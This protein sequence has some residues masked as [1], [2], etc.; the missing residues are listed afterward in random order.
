VR[1]LRFLFYFDST[2][3]IKTGLCAGPNAGAIIEPERFRSPFDS[4]LVYETA[5]G[6]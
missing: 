5:L 6:G 2:R 1:S 3:A 4:G